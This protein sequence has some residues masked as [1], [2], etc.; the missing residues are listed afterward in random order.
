MQIHK[1]DFVHCDHL[2]GQASEKVKDDRIKAM[3]AESKRVRLTALEDFKAS[4]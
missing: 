1:L 2:G 4:E 3:E